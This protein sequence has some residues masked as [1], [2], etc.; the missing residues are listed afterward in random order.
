M[1]CFFNLLFKT[2]CWSVYSI[3]YNVKKSCGPS[4]YSMYQVY[5]KKKTFILHINSHGSNLNYFT[6]VAVFSLFLF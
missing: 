6:Y 5:I 3:Y 4:I 2:L 1:F